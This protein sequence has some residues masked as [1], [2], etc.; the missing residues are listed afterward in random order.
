MG[1]RSHHDMT[2]P[3]SP[4]NQAIVVHQVNEV[5]GIALPTFA[6]HTSY[7]TQLMLLFDYQVLPHSTPLNA[8]PDPTISTPPSRSPTPLSL[9]PRESDALL[10]TTLADGD[11]LQESDISDSHSECPASDSQS[12]EASTMVTVSAVRDSLASKRFFYED[13]KALKGG[14]Q[15]IIDAALSIMTSKRHSPISKDNAPS[16]KDA[17]KRFSSSTERTLVHNVW[18][19]LKQKARH[20]VGEALPSD[21]T[22]AMQW[23]KRAWDMDYLE[24][25]FESDLTKDCI[26][27]TSHTVSSKP[28][29]SCD[30]Y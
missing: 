19:I 25:V 29:D 22:K 8:Q 10:L 17:I 30:E 4:L 3:L 18:C 28:K 9:S 20:V 21:D 15:A 14:G 12:S 13:E 24:C 5:R 16:L 7:G 26:P 27:D 6:I 11:H 1:K 23:V 2:G